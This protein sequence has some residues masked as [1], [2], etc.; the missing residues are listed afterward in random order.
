[1]FPADVPN[2]AEAPNCTSGLQES[3]LPLPAP[4]PDYIPCPNCGE[5]EVE[6]WCYE[7][8]T[9]CHNC[10][11]LIPHQPPACFGNEYCKANETAH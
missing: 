5:S 4:F 1:M 11:A 10:G 3:G 8:Q 6:V 2:G 7:T 9:R